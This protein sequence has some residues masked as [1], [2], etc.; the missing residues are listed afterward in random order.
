MVQVSKHVFALSI[1]LLSP[2]DG[3]SIEYQKVQ[4]SVN[5]QLAKCQ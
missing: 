2:D 3:D 1:K 4:R 5:L